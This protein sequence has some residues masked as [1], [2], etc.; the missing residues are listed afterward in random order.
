MVERGDILKDFAAIDQA[1]AI[2]CELRWQMRTD[3]RLEGER[4]GSV[5]RGDGQGEIWKSGREAYY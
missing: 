1:Q 4:W 3:E 5:R 2:V